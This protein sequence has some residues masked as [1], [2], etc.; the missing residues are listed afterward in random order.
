MSQQ[1]H[2]ITDRLGERRVFKDDWLKLDT[3]RKWEIEV[4]GE[5]RQLTKTQW[6]LLHALCQNA[7]RAS[8]HHYMLG[9][10]YGAFEHYGP[11]NYSYHMM[12]LKRKLSVDGRQPLITAVRGFGYILDP[13]FER[14]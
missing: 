10:L 7:G 1:E 8:P 11:E 2:S 5:P 4:R 3:A 6:L 14:S 13:Y 12:H 9:Q